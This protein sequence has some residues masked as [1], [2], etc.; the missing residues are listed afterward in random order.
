MKLKYPVLL[1]IIISFAFPSPLYSQSK[2]AANLTEPY[3]IYNRKINQGDYLGAYLELKKHETEYKAS[4]QFVRNFLQLMSII[5][6]QVGEY[7]AANS[8]L[9][10]FFS[11]QLKPQKDLESSPIDNY[12][13]RGAIDAIASAA[14]KQQVIMINEEHDTPMHRAFTTRL[15]PILYA[16][17]FRYLAAETISDD[18]TELNKRGYPT[19]KTGFYTAD[20]VYGDM[21]RTALRLGFKIVPYEH[22]RVDCKNPDDN[23][24]FCQ[25][26][27]ERGQ[28][29]NLYDRI[30][31]NEPNAKILVHV[32][33]GHNQEANFETWAMMAWHFKQISKIDPFTIG[34][35]HLSERSRPENE[36]PL[37]RYAAAK[38]KFAEPSVFQSKDGKLW[39][40]P[41][42]D[43]TIF[44]PRA[45]YKDGRPAWLEMGGARK[46][47]RLYGKVEN[48]VAMPFLPQTGGTFL[49]QIFA[50]NE[51]NEAIPVDQI[52]VT[53]AKKAPVLMLPT[54]GDFRVRA[55][56]ESGKIV[57]E[58]NVS[59]K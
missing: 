58:T 30:L 47:L 19:Q 8:Y 15:L 22:M 20:P 21:I 35:M 10:D 25:D 46:S 54:K 24:D 49:V 57:V 12:E 45:I 34:Q 6:S 56:D 23:P 36:F 41:A 50:A 17:G 51:P 40:E 55:I 39:S 53:D 5:A 14:E 37:Y 3:L 18:D 27:R 26:E 2:T 13:R 33:R 4:P 44:H 59:T 38:W 42:N 29:Q 16:K 7:S 31:K 9:D 52:I 48:S 43:L 1:F 11:R 32:G 28:A